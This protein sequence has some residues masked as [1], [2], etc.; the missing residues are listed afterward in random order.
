MAGGTLDDSLRLAT[1][2][3]LVLIKERQCQRSLDHRHHT[4]RDL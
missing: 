2:I 3:A 4:D 1:T